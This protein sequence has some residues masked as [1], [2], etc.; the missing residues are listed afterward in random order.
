[1]TPVLLRLIIPA[2][3]L[4][5]SA[6]MALVKACCSG[7]A[8]AR[9]WSLS[10]RS[11]GPRPK[12]G[13][14]V[15]AT[16]WIHAASLGESKLLV[17]FLDILRKKHPGQSYLLTAT[18]KTGVEYL[19]GRDASD[20]AGV[21]FLPLDTIGLMQQLIET[22]GVRRVWV[23]ETELWPSMIW[24]CIRNSV[25]LGLVNARIEERSLSSYKRLGWLL[26]DLLTYPDTVLAQTAAYARRFEIL[27]IK[28]D[29][30]HV[31]G[32]LKSFV[33]VHPLSSEERVQR[34]RALS[35]DDTELCLTAGCL[36]ATEGAILL[37]ALEIVR[38]AGLACKCI[39]VPRHLREVPALV[40]E[41]GPDAVV[42]PEPR[43]EIA[44]NV[45]VIDKMGIL[46]AMYRIADAAFVGGTFDSTGGHNMWDAAQY[47]IPVVFGPDIHTQEESAGSLIS[48]GVGFKVNDAAGL[49]RTLIEVLGNGRQ[50]F[51]R[52][53]D[54]F[55]QRVN[56]RKN[57]FEDVIQ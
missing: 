11:S 14:T 32:N 49:A 57:A 18:T 31:T 25:P 23:M 35:L 20:I 38:A 44:W 17:R 30:I 43:C 34:R 36:H 48:A 15:G 26:S 42:C 29:R 22:F 53:R 3:S 5:L 45:C 41:L 46:D 37:Q 2:Y 9:N 4:V 28:K 40:R 55:M 24:A 21:G 52:A 7:T 54:E 8:I 27:G 12:K 16:V 39:V 6:G 19:R 51:L 13:K 10:E 33:T 56:R 1:M 50:Q 47:G